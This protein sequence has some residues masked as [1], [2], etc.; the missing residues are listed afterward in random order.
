MTSRSPGKAADTAVAPPL[1]VRRGR[2]P[3]GGVSSRGAQ[4]LEMKDRNASDDGLLR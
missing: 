2:D 3:G 1:G 4:L